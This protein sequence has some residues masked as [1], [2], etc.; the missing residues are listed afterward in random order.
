[1]SAPDLRS[2]RVSLPGSGAVWIT[3]DSRRSACD[4]AESMLGEGHSLPSST[5][6]TAEILDEYEDGDA[7]Q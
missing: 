6:R 5:A 4:L 1:M 7:T 3:A 2:Y